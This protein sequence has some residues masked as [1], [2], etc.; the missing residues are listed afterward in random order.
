MLSKSLYD[1]IKCI[2]LNHGVVVQIFYMYL[3]ITVSCHAVTQALSL[4]I[5]LHMSWESRSSFSLSI[6][7]LM[8]V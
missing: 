7:E 6:S 8:C 2:I 3:Y 5:V 1:G 4:I